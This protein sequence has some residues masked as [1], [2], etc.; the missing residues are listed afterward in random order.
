MD[1]FFE[2]H[3]SSISSAIALSKDFSRCGKCRNNLKM[4]PNYNKLFCEECKY[5]YGLP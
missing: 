4:L 5:M 1:F 2:K 3:F